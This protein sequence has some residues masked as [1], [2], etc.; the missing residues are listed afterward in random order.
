[1]YIVFLIILFLICCNTWSNSCNYFNLLIAFLLTGLFAVV[2][3]SKY[4]NE[5]K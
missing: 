3:F 1:M 5:N 2:A 4:K